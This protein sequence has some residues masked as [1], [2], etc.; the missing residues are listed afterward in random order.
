MKIAYFLRNH[1]NHRKVVFS[2]V[3]FSILSVKPKNVSEDRLTYCSIAS[4]DRDIPENR[5]GNFHLQYQFAYLYFPIG[6]CP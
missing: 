3:N 1:R 6:R 2:N 4:E 5:M